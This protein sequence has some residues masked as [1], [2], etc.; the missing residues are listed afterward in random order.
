MSEIKD[1]RGGVGCADGDQ[2]EQDGSGA[3][4]TWPRR[5]TGDSLSSFLSL[6][7]QIG[8]NHDQRDGLIDDEEKRRLHISLVNAIF[9]VENTCIF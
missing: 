2:N 1:R 3:R 9:N 7:G 4:I 5:R 6:E 8:S